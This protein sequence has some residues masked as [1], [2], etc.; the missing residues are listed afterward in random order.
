MIPAARSLPFALALALAARP[1]AAFTRDLSP[2]GVARAWR[3]PPPAPLLVDDLPGLPRADVSAA[4][5]RSAGVWSA[6]PG[7]WLSF[8]GPAR[9]SPVR[10][11]VTRERWPLSPDF[12]AHTDLIDTSPPGTVAGAVIRLNAAH[13]RFCLSAC[14]PGEVALEP[15][16]LHEL[17]HVIGLGHSGV[18]GAVMAPGLGSS[19]TGSA[20]LALSDDDR[21]GVLAIYAGAPPTPTAQATQPAPGR[22]APWAWI[23]ALGAALA[24]VCGALR[25]RRARRVR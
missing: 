24:I 7:S 15:V 9:G 19:R 5:A 2:V 23:A 20:P 3:Q 11:E 8:T 13:H 12:V 1:S 18:R 17:G 6:V 4:L 22:R 21:R 10:V 14:A 25:A 16:L